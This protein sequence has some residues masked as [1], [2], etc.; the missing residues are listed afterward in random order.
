MSDTHLRS[1]DTE[2]GEIHDAEIVRDSKLPD[3]EGQHVDF[4]RLKLSSVSDLETPEDQAIHIDDTVRLFVEGRVTRVDHV[5][6]EKTGKL[7]RVHTIKVVD[8]VQLPWNFD[9]GAFE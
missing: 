3:F 5:V 9:T 4:S 7:K 1:V 6:D 2:T 8:A